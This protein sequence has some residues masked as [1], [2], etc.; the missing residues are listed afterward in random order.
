M[1]ENS[2]NKD[3]LNVKVEIDNDYIEYQVRQ[4]TKDL[5]EKNAQ[6]MADLEIIATKE[7][8]RQAQILGCEATV[9]AVQNAKLNKS[10][11][12]LL[13]DQ[14]I[15]GNNNNEGFNSEEDAIIALNRASKANNTKAKEIINKLGK[16]YLEKPVNIEYEGKISDLARKPVKGSRESDEE[17]A[18]RLGDY[19]KRQSW[20]D[21]NNYKDNEV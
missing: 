4:R 10:D 8:Q 1:G 17:F 9:E 2:E 3:Q 13:N 21:L 5:E 19:Q 12:A 15:S 16:K 6:L 14:Q 20:R 18:V 11:T 7:L